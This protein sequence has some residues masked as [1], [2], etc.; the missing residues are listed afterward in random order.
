MWGVLIPSDSFG[1]AM[2]RESNPAMAQVGR[3]EERS[4]WKNFTD[5]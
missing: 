5:I 1:C 2:K 3:E 4:D